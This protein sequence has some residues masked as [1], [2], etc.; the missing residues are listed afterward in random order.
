MRT[1][2]TA[3][4]TGNAA[5]ENPDAG[6][7]TRVYRRLPSV[8]LARRR[9][10]LTAAAGFYVPRGRKEEGGSHQAL[11]LYIKQKKQK[12]YSFFTG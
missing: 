8:Q 4:S 1:M 12:L 11:R 5:A 2:T 9:H 7:M 6:I 3:R 10:L